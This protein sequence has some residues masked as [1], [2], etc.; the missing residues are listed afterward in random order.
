MV[1]IKDYLNNSQFHKLSQILKTT[2]V[3]KHYLQFAKTRENQLFR[4]EQNSL[5]F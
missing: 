2:F 3:E 5:P 1:K 4:R